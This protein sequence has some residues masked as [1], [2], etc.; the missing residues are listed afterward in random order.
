MIRFFNCLFYCKF[1]LKRTQ[2]PNKK[3]KT[4]T[5]SNSKAVSPFVS[6]FLNQLPTRRCHVEQ[7][8][9]D[10]PCTLYN[11]LV[12]R[13]LKIIFKARNQFLCISLCEQ[14]KGT[15]NHTHDNVRKIVRWNQVTSFKKNHLET[16]KHI[17]KFKLDN[18]GSRKLNDVLKRKKKKRPVTLKSRFSHRVEGF[19][20]ITSIFFH[21]A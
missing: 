14:H 5:T 2:M 15:S 13:A 16:P 7:K 19:L 6:A 11:P 1:S 3:P 4:C 10:W 20:P 17:R 12:K 8:T 9:R 18:I 21:P